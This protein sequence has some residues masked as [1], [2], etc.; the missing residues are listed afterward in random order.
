LEPQNLDIWAAATNIFWKKENKKERS[1]GLCSLSAK[2]RMA[3]SL[4]FQGFLQK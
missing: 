2:I 1:F 4:A 3:T